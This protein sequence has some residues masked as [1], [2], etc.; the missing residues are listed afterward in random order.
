LLGMLTL[1]KGSRDIRQPIGVMLI[2]SPSFIILSL[3]F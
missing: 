2:I 3:F 1:H